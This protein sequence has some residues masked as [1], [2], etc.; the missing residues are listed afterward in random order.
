MWMDGWM[1]AQTLSLVCMRLIDRI[2][3]CGY[4]R[5]EVIRVRTLPF[6]FWSY[7]VYMQRGQSLKE[8]LCFFGISL[9]LFLFFLLKNHSPPFSF[10]SSGS[11]NCN[12]RLLFSILSVYI[13]VSDMCVV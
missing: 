1:E 11:I 3:L 7:Q 2:L 6:L 4:I 13:Y 12:D 10:S 8:L 5:S 9:S